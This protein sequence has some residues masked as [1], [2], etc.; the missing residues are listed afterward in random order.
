[1]PAAVFPEHGGLLP[2]MP[3]P[4][5]GG[6][7]PP[8]RLAP[9]SDS[10]S[11]VIDFDT[12]KVDRRGRGGRGDGE[13]LPRF[14]VPELT[15]DIRWDAS[16]G[17][18][19]AHCLAKGHGSCRF[20][21]TAHKRPLAAL[22]AWLYWAEEHPEASGAQHRRQ[23]GRFCGEG[24]LEDREATRDWFTNH[25][26]AMTTPLAIGEE[27]ALRYHART[28]DKQVEWRKIGGS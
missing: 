12:Q 20:N 11:S 3:A 4:S 8:P 1:M 25:T 26:D 23:R 22:I 21:R 7:I 16:T 13:S 17:T 2:A 24:T 28:I 9:P 14:K 5:S 10:D 6:P 19:S 18:L 15:G 27:Q